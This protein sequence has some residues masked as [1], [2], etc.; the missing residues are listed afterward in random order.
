[1]NSGLKSLVRYDGG[2]WAI[3]VWKRE[4]RHGSARYHA[5]VGKPHGGGIEIVASILYLHTA[6]QAMGWATRRAAEVLA[7][8]YSAVEWIRWN[9]Q[10][11]LAAAVGG[12]R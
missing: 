1:M 3:M 12:A 2:P 6:R 11:A 7:G 10:R 5:A 9:V 8:W 4:M